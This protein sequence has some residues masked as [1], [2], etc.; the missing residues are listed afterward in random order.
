M[1]VRTE[2]LSLH[3]TTLASP[4]NVI[5]PLLAFLSSVIVGFTHKLASLAIT[6]ETIDCEAPVSGKQLTSRPR[7]HAPCGPSHSGI[8]GVGKL[9]GVEKAPARV[10]DET[11]D[12]ADDGVGHD[13]PS[14]V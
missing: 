4:N 2:C 11:E 10:T 3:N 14:A 1:V 13:A 8:S 12:D 5:T 9:E 7:E 6:A